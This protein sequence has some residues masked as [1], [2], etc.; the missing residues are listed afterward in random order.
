MKRFSLKQGVM[1]GNWLYLAKVIME[2]IGKKPAQC[3]FEPFCFL[4]KCWHSHNNE[5]TSS[6]YTWDQIDV[7]V[8]LKGVYNVVN[9]KL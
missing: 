3:I 5:L 6:L 9:E 1:E 4:N 8:R 2:L 7:S